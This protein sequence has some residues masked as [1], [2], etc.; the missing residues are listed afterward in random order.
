MRL[1]GHVSFLAGFSPKALSDKST[2]KI[3]CLTFDDGPDP[4]STPGLLD[5]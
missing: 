1:S 5:I 4:A 3:L 2:E